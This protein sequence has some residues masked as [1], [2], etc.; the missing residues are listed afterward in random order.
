[1]R[2]T[3]A[4]AA[5]LALLLAWTIGRNAQRDADSAAIV[6]QVRQLNQLTTV[7]YTVERVVGIREPKQP[8]GEESILLLVRARVQAGV[9]LD[10]LKEG[11]V[12]KRGDGATIVRLP[13]P[14]IL[15]VAIDEKQT[16]VWDRRVTWW[17]PWVP[18]SLDLEKT[19]RQRGLDAAREAALEMGILNQA[20]R[21]AETSIR[22][23][24][25][26]AGVKTVEFVPAGTS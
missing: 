19:A 1:M 11:D 12:V 18:F 23:L 4:A 2:W 21:N 7:E 6:A 26:L 17:T 25:E 13:R 8:L 24:L 16:K 22:T 20:E 9:R 10:R 15:E 5:V 14:E 3:L